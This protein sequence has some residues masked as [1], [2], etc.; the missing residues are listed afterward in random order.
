VTLVLA[1][2]ALRTRV[3]SAATMRDQ[4]EHIARTIETT[5]ETVVIGVLPFTRPFPVAPVTGFGIL[6]DAVTIETE[7]GDL[8]IA[9]PAEVDRYWRLIRLLLD[10]AATG[11]EAAALVRAVA[12]EHVETGRSL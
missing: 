10:A 5:P 2:G 4:L 6:D 3:A 7:G 11:P 9:D 8:T 1:E 12:T